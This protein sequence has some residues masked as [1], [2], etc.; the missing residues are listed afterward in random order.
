[1]VEK[2]ASTQR[3]ASTTGRRSMAQV[4]PPRYTIQALA[5]WAT[6]V[7]LLFVLPDARAA[8]TRHLA[9]GFT[10]L[11]RNATVVIMP[12]DI[13]LF[14]VSAGGVMEPKADWT[15]TASKYF[16]AALAHKK[17]D[18]GVATVE[19]RDEDADDVAEIN[20]LHAAIARAI[21][22]H[23]FGPSFLK[24]PT[25]HGKL[26]WSLG[27]PARLLKQKT[28]ADYALF[29]WVRDSYASIERIAT[30]IGLAILGVGIF[31]GAMQ[32]GYASLVDLDTGRVVW[33]NRLIRLTGD[34]RQPERAAE[35]VDTLL[36]HF[37]SVK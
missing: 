21:Q 22:L 14:V 9:P 36:E 8:E 28:G 27:E 3:A 7:A 11:P 31:P 12:T 2:P 18:L 23:H 4:I 13:E 1:M 17:T 25:K 29:S 16:N 5:A 30:T 32:T 37:P 20:T 33:F 10:S 26:D 34:L 24:L 19:L 35:T 6:V 15:E